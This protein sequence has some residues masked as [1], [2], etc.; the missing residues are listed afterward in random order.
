MPR[1]PETIYS[2]GTRSTGVYSSSY[3]LTVFPVA[4]SARVEKVI[5]IQEEW[6]VCLSTPT[7]GEGST[8]A[9]KV[10]ATYVVVALF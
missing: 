8:G 6:L 3:V 5:W 9:S 1:S 10:G 2:M 7:A 4:H